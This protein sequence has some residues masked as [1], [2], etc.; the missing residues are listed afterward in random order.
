MS[1]TESLSNNKPLV[2][3]MI[4]AIKEH[5][6]E[7]RLASLDF[8]LE[9][10]ARTHMQVLPTLELWLPKEKWLP[11]FFSC[12]EEYDIYKDFV[13]V[14]TRKNNIANRNKREAD[15]LPLSLVDTRPQRKVRMECIGC[16]YTQFTYD[17]LLKAFV[18]SDCLAIQVK[19]RMNDQEDNVRNRMKIVV[20]GVTYSRLSTFSFF[21]RKFQGLCPHRAN[22]VEFQNIKTHLLE[23]NGRL[24][25]L[26][27][28]K[29]KS[30]LYRLKYKHL[31]S[32]VYT[33][34]HE[35][36]THRIRWQR[37]YIDAMRERFNL[38]EVAN[39]NTSF[40]GMLEIMYSIAAELA[41]VCPHDT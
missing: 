22:E 38:R 9:L 21:L 32:C 23:E 26:V 37:R 25:K 4:E 11:E 14:M 19:R 31:Y 35:L 33:L 13:K 30:L 6:P 18:C 15:H 5:N 36:G 39:G 20:T 8:I 16:H 7:N 24:D 40:K 12:E 1:S 10:G 2:N 28:S 3:R 27:F 34:M 41:I 29:V 17:Y